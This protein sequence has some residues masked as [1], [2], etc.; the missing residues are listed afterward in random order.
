MTDEQES[1][2]IKEKIRAFFNKLNDEENITVMS[3]NVEWR[4]D[5]TN[6]QE[7][8]LMKMNDLMLLIQLSI[9]FGNTPNAKLGSYHRTNLMKIFE[10]L[11]LDHIDDLP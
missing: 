8:K 7:V 9:A 11:N 6:K 10:D 3:V 4:A 5:M 1:Q 2:L